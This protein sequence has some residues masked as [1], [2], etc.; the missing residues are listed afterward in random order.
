M[1]TRALTGTDLHVSVVGLGTWAIG[2]IAEEWGQVD[3]RESIATIH[4]ALDLGI[5]LIDT[6]PIYG[7]GHSE[8]VVGKA[9]LGR[10]EEVILATKCGLVASKSRGAPPIRR[11]TRE[12]VLRECEQSLRRLR[13]EVI[14]LYQCHWPDPETHIRETMGALVTLLEQGKIRAIGVS[15]FSCEQIA[16]ARE[17]GPIHSLQPPFSLLNRRAADDLLPYCAEHNLSVIAYD[18]LAR[19]LLTGKFHRDSEIGGMRRRDPDY[20]GSRFLRNLDVVA[21]LGEIAAAHGKTVAQLAVRWAAYH[22]GVTTALFGAKRPS[23]VL[24]NVGGVGWTL[25]ED[26]QQRIDQLLRGNAVDT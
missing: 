26:N 7:A 21:R 23:Q 4:Q 12:S 14:D 11:L 22:P 3:D 17:F 2:G 8:A 1:D 13:T 24:E 5:N 9:I 20:V 25:T 16:A 10:R 19:G 6:A 18:V 15:N